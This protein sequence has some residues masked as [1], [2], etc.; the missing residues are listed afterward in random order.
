MRSTT[1]YRLFVETDSDEDSGYTNIIQEEDFEG[2]EECEGFQGVQKGSEIETN[3]QEEA[4]P[5][6]PWDPSESFFAYI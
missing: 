4:P 2:D 3:G 6:T 1:Q 5:P